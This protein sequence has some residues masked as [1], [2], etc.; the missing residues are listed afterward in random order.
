M[1]GD[2]IHL[3]TAAAKQFYANYVFDFMGRRD[4]VQALPE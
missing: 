2:G 3:G 1:A 4:L